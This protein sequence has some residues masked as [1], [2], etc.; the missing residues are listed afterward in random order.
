L[1]EFST[2]AWL[3]Q[4]LQKPCIS[5][6]LKFDMTASLALPGKALARTLKIESE[7]EPGESSLFYVNGQ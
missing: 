2:L 6:Q 1:R 7:R 4:E 5:A 3:S